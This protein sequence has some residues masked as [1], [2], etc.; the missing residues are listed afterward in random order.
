MRGAKFIIIEGGEQ[1]LYSSDGSQPVPARPSDKGRLHARWG[2]GKSN[3]LSGK[4]NKLC[5]G[6]EILILR[7]TE[8]KLKCV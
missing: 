5:V 4:G 3:V 7:L 1:K 6:A 2:V 8:T